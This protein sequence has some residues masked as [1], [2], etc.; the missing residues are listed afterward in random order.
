[1]AVSV[2]DRLTAPVEDRSGRIV[3]DDALRLDVADGR[4]AHGEERDAERIALHLFERVAVKDRDPD[5]DGSGIRH[6]KKHRLGDLHGGIRQD[7]ILS[8]VDRGGVLAAVP[9]LD[10]EGAV[11]DV[12]LVVGPPD[13]DAIHIDID[14]EGLDPADRVAGGVVEDAL[15]REHQRYGRRARACC[16]RGLSQGQAE[17]RDDTGE[18]RCKKSYTD[19]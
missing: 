17:T 13:G 19:L 5:I 3:G 1:V 7:G 10:E 2:D 14:L 9:D 12:D 18:E 8:R 4:G 15:D 16:S 11:D 6:A